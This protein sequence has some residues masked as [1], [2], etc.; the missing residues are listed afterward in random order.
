M[1]L[2][3][4]HKNLQNKKRISMNIDFVKEPYDIFTYIYIYY[5][6]IYK[7]IFFIQMLLL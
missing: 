6:H 2:I 4:G 5:K 1:D 3:G 7:Y